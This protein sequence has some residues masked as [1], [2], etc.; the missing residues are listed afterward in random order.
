MGLGKGWLI[1]RRFEYIFNLMLLRLC[2]LRFSIFD[3]FVDDSC[4]LG[5]RGWWEG[6]FEYI[7]QTLMAGRRISRTIQPE[8]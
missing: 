8:Y 5:E 6:R 4:G 3:I 1:R 2:N 7:W